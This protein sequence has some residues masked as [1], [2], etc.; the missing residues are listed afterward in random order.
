MAERVLSLAA[1]TVLDL[2]PADTVR[3]AA[4]AG[5]DAAGLW[6]D[7]ASWTTATTSEVQRALA[8]TGLQALDIEPLIFGRGAVPVEALLDAAVATGAEFVL[9]CSGPADLGEFVPQFERL[10]ALAADR[11]P[12]VTIALEFLP[13]FTVGTLDAAVD[14]VQRVG[15]PNCGVLVDTLHLSRS[16]NS[17]ADLATVAAQQPGRVSYLQL[18]DASVNVPTDRV[19]LRDEALN[20]RLLA[21]EGVL[22]IADVV[23]AVPGV[24]LSVELR[25]RAFNERYP[26]AFERARVVYDSFVRMRTH[27]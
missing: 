2:S 24:P 21:G 18:A 5:F 3:A 25:S 14:V 13:I 27:S 20:G 17:P 9:A 26:D 19:A 6:F 16:G 10:C 4:D 8:D 1:G 12:H 23:R 11:A 22:P 7:P 15:A